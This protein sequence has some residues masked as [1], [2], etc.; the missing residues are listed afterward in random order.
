MA[1]LFARKFLY[2]E[3][4]HEGFDASGDSVS[5]GVSSRFIRGTVQPV[6][7]EEAIAYS[8]GGRNTGVVKVYSSERLSARTQEGANK[9]G[10]IQQGGFWYEIVDELVFGNLPKITHWKYIASKIPADQI[11]E[12]LNDG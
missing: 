6:S 7:G 9:Q 3:I 12:G 4:A 8:E 1:T 10:Y 11:P 2:R 5:G